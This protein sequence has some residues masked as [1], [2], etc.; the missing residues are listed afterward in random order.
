MVCISD[1]LAESEG[2]DAFSRAFSVV[3]VGSAYE[4]AAEILARPVLALVVEFSRLGEADAQ[5]VRIS[6]DRGVPVYGIGRP[7]GLR[8]DEFDDIRP[9]EL[10][11]LPGLLGPVDGRSQAGEA[12]STASAE[13][14]RNEAAASDVSN[15]AKRQ[16]YQ[17]V[18]EEP[19]VPG[20][21]TPE[22]LA[23]LLENE[24]E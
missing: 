10:H 24:R 13:G 5:L 16:Y 23:A 4:A 22:E 15:M 9:T 14:R 17:A 7:G 21:L 1:R 12:E 18:T 2:F 11:E 6:G 3:R 19:V 8:A 20:V